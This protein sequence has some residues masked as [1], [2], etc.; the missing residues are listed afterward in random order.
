MRDQIKE[1]RFAMLLFAIIAVLS[2][3]LVPSVGAADSSALDAVCNLG[4]S[5]PQPVA[6]T[7]NDIVLDCHDSG[8]AAANAS[9]AARGAT[10]NFSVVASEGYKLSCVSVIASD[11]ALV[12]ISWLGGSFYSFRM[13]DCAVVIDVNFQLAQAV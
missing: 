11:G 8:Y 1:I 12:E 6:T 2:A 10:V 5:F 9:G 13:P 4:G 3:V 7:I